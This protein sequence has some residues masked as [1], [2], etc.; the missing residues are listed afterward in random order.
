MAES[1]NWA[2]HWVILFTQREEVDAKLTSGV[3][4]NGAVAP[5]GGAGT[6]E[7]IDG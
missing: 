1:D 3:L 5:A 2:L 4:R 7:E 6:A